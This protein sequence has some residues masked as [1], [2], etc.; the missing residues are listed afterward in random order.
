MAGT[1][2]ISSDDPGPDLVVS[3]LTAPSAAG[4][5]QTMNVTDTTKNQGAGLAPPSATSFYLSVNTAF[6]TPDVFLGSRSVP[7]LLQNA[8]SVVSTSLTIPAGTAAGNYYLIARADGD[9]LVRDQRGQQHPTGRPGRRRARSRRRAPSP[10]PRR[11]CGPD[12]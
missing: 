7:E 2:S 5:G 10:L 9:T 4:A 11:R 3:A 8:T 6:D 12:H 1:V